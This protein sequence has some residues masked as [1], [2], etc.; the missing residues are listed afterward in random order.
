MK[1]TFAESAE[2]LAS[3]RPPRT[4]L[5]PANAWELWMPYLMVWVGYA[6]ARIAVGA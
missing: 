2:R 4:S 6:L 3:Y 5:E 1:T